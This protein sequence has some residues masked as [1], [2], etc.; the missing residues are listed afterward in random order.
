MAFDFYKEYKNYSTE[1][2]LKISL[3]PGRYTDEAILTAKQILESREVSAE[4]NRNARRHVEFQELAAASKRER[5]SAFI[6]F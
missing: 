3:Q 6:I 4:D 1:E 2:L 5:S